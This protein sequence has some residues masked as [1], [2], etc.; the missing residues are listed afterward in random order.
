[1]SEIDLAD[2]RKRAL[3]LIPVSR[4][5]VARLDRFVDLL[6]RWQRTMNLIAPSTVPHLWTRHVADSLQLVPLAGDA[7]SWIDLGTGGGF[8]GMAVACELAGRPGATVHLVESNQKK[9]AFLRLATAATGA[10]A[11]VHNERI[12]DFVSAFDG[13]VEVVT[14][15]ALAPLHELLDYAHPLMKMGAQALFPKGQD[16]EVELTAAAKY[17]SMDATL[18]PSRTNPRARIV[19]VRKVERRGAP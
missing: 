17:W 15:R 11:L 10:P 3:A 4:E 5:T 16:V 19:V 6:L 14:A 2:D 9:S 7:R 13:H 12:T 18:V 1:V 8:P